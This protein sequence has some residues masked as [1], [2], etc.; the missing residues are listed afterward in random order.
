MKIELC[1][2]SLEAIQLAKELNVDRIELCQNLEQGGMT[3]SPGIIDY[4]VALGI[5]TH[6][7]IRPRP[8]GFFYNQDEIEVML[9]DILECASMNV[10]GVVIGALNEF[11]V[12]DEDAVGMMV[13]KAGTMDVTFHRA[14]DDTYNFEKSLDTLINLGVKRVL[15]S[16]LG[17]SVESGLLNLKAM[18]EYAA[19]RIEIM[20]GGG[21]NASN[22]EKL[23]AEVRP[24][25]IHFSG[26]R[27]FLL[28]E[29]SMFSETI[30]K[31]SREKVERLLELA[32]HT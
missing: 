28:D 11:G 2:G 26:T 9:R 8:G 25:A 21:I 15:S 6:V 17:S 10:R 29:R 30:L 12:I 7:L 13:E 31:V 22:I 19:G 16:G 1:A 18:Q 32:R 4:A 3:P 14:F 23:I 20:C 5:E 24:D 27:K